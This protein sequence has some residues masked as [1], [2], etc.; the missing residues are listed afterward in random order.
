LYRISFL[1]V[2]T[3]SVLWF[4]KMKELGCVPFVKVI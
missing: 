3:L 1:L 2:P 4:Q